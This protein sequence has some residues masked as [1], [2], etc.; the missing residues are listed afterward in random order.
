MK[1]KVEKFSKLS[2]L[3]PVQV[4]HD[5]FTQRELA[6]LDLHCPNEG[7]DWSGTPQDLQVRDKKILHTWLEDMNFILII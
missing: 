1:E 2:S 7:C 3:F 5:R 6:K 4:F